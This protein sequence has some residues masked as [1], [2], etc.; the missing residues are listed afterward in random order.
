MVLLRGSNE[1]IKNY[2]I[3]HKTVYYMFSAGHLQSFTYSFIQQEFNK[4]P[5]CV[6]NPEFRNG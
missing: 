2:F 4:G 5:P 3:K 6:I 1:I